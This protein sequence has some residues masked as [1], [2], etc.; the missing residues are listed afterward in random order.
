MARQVA[1]RAGRYLYHVETAIAVTIFTTD[2]NSVALTG[3]NGVT[4][5]VTRFLAADRN[6]YSPDASDCHQLPRLRQ[7]HNL[8]HHDSNS[9]IAVSGN[10]AVGQSQAIPGRCKR[11]HSDLLAQFLLYT[12][13]YMS[14]GMRN[15]LL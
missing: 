4:H 6:G 13:Q 2:S 15:V 1:C 7:L 14:T 5:A 8:H 3:R 9:T 12:T 11:R 10:G